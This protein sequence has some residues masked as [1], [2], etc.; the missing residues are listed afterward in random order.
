MILRAT[1]VAL[2]ALALA[3]CMSTPP[4]TGTPTISPTGTPS[5]TPTATLTPLATL[6]SIPTLEP[7][8]TPTQAPTP[9]PTIQPTPLSDWTAPEL[10]A[11]GDFNETDVAVDPQG[12]VHVAATGYGRHIRGIWYFTNTSGHWTSHQVSSPTRGDKPGDGEPSIALDTD[13]SVWIAF[14]RWTC[15]QCAPDS[16]D[17]TWYVTNASGTWSE[18]RQIAQDANLSPSLVVR[19][20][21]VHVAY[22]ERTN[23]GHGEDY[24]VWYSTNASGTW[25]TTQ[26]ARKG[27]APQLSLDAEGGAQILYAAPNDIRLVTQRPS[28]DFGAPESLP[29]STGQSGFEMAIDAGSGL[30]WAGWTQ[31]PDDYSYI[32]VMVARRGP[33]GWFQP[34]LVLTNAYLTGL[35][36]SGIANVTASDNDPDDYMGLVYAWNASTDGSFHEDHLAPGGGGYSSIATGTLGRAYVVYVI[37][38]PALA[39]PG[40]W[41]TMH[42]LPAEL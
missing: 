38:D 10:I 33:D 35:A 21:I 13:G 7:T 40:V 28:G 12:A 32:N 22:N 30:M 8:A 39:Q 2:A 4:P 18:P 19:D 14:A 11:R 42:L 23:S 31:H 1:A 17:G 6:P 41:F 34:E 3:A 20:G 25:V 27:Y 15:W 24:P 36:V 16:P 9:T 29:G 5:P 26:V 37:E